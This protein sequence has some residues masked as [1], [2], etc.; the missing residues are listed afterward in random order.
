MSDEVDYLLS[1]LGKEGY[2]AMDCWMPTDPADKIDAGTFLDYLKNTLDDKISPCVRVYELEDV[3]RRTDE[4]IDAL[5]DHI[6]QFAHCTLKICSTY[7]AI[8]SGAAAM[9][10]GNTINAVQKSH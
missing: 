4:T 6:C 2:G 7:Y 8:E 9:C 3:K 1:I 5:I 10:T